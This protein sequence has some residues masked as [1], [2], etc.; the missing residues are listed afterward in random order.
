MVISSNQLSIY[1]RKKGSWGTN[2][3]QL[4]IVCYIEG[5]SSCTKCSGTLKVVMM[6]MVDD[7]DFV[8]SANA[9]KQ[10]RSYRRFQY[11]DFIKFSRIYTERPRTTNQSRSL[12]TLIYA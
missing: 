1:I 7:I 5:A 11:L 10:W 12:M 4:G 2:K 3:H 9:H 8:Y 6:I